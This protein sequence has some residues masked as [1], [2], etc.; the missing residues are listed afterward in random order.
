[1]NPFKRLSRFLRI[2]RR[3]GAFRRAMER[4]MS[5]EE[6]RKYSDS[7]YPPTPDENE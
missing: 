5:P 2:S 7:L 3:L 4:G 1:M 6:A